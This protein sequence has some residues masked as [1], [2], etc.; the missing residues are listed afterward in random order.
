MN[1]NT[2]MLIKDYSKRALKITNLFLNMLL[3]NKEKFDL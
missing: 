2:L 1:V 3:K